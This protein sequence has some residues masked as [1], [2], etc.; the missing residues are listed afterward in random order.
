M[1]GEGEE[2]DLLLLLLA[3]LLPRQCEE[4]RWELETLTTSTHLHLALRERE[5]ALCAAARAANAEARQLEL[6]SA[7]MQRKSHLA[8][9]QLAAHLVGGTRG[10]ALQQHRDALALQLRQGQQEAARMRLDYA[11]YEQAGPEFT[12]IAREYATI[13]HHITSLRQDLANL[14]GEEE[15]G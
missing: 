15:A 4:T 8:H 12:A 14:R 2:R 6:V 11:A 5:A 10:Q 1:A 7:N 9:A 3:P 13:G